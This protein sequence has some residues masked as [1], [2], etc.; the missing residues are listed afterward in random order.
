MIGFHRRL[1]L[2]AF[3][4]N[5][6]PHPTKLHC[7]L[8][9]AQMSFGCDFFV[10]DVV[11]RELESM[12]FPARVLAVQPSN[13]YRITYI[14]DGN[15]ED[16]VPGDQLRKPK[17]ANELEKIEAPEKP[18]MIVAPASNIPP[19]LYGRE[20]K[21]GGI[22]VANLNQPKVFNHEEMRNKDVGV[23]VEAKGIDDG[24]DDVKDSRLTLNGEAG[25]ALPRGGG[26][27][28]LRAL[29]KNDA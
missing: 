25:I 6:A 14:D 26:L 18:A 28:A 12:H 10:G 2:V 13:K 11:E 9:G 5:S 15:T 16:N 29:R 7:Q 23:K 19:T 20:S 1:R 21:E 8:H 24:G 4:T 17:N 27:K 22:S 3:L